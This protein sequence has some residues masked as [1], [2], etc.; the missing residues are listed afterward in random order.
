MTTLQDNQVSVYYALGWHGIMRE[1]VWFWN[2]FSVTKH[3]KN[4]TFLTFQWPWELFWAMRTLLL[5]LIRKKLYLQYLRFRTH[6]MYRAV[7]QRTLS[8]GSIIC[9]IFNINVTFHI[10]LCINGQTKY[11]KL[12]FPWKKLLIS[13]NLGV[14]TWKISHFK[15]MLQN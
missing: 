7:F 2:F 8:C 5:T 13:S 6:W 10:I 15:L 4:V 3:F 14:D 11:K 1:W 9:Y 12:L